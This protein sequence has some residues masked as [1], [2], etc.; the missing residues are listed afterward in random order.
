MLLN[1]GHVIVH[2]CGC[3]EVSSRYLRHLAVATVNRI[4]CNAA[5]KS[6][7]CPPPNYHISMSTLLRFVLISYYYFF[8]I[9]FFC[10]SFSARSHPRSCNGISAANVVPG[11][12]YCST[13]P[14][15]RHPFPPPFQ[16]GSVAQRS[17]CYGLWLASDE[18]G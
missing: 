6:K 12:W 3:T 5:V 8:C 4:A 7:Q 17:N 9:S 16:Q 2:A 1:N 11:R 10:F 15:R 18:I 14:L 13:L